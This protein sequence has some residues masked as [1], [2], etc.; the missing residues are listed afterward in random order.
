MPED[1]HM[2]GP[3]PDEDEKERVDRELIE[4]LNELRVAL[5][6]V[7]VLFAFLLT[8]PFSQRFNEVTSAQRA[9]YFV[10]FLS[11]ALSVALLI[12]PSSYHRIQFRRG[13]KL[14][15][16]FTS[17]RMVIAGMAFVAISVTGVVFVITDVVLGV[18][19]AS[20]ITAAIAGWFIWFW[21][22]LPLSRR[23]EQDR[24]ER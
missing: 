22:G 18:P 19:A 1:D 3:Q 11:A 13:D 16:L 14:R 12:A 20:A 9:A 24:R 17:N 8:V 10:A 4:L 7:Q 6:G 5:P 21:Y 23:V 15:M 2:Q